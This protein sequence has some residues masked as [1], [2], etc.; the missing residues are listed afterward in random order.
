MRSRKS[1]A[2]LLAVP[3]VCLLAGVFFYFL[4]PVHARLAWRVENLWVGIKRAI[5]PPEQV[6]FVPQEQVDAAVQATLLALTPSPSPVTPTAVGPTDTPPP[7]PTPTSS[8]T[9]IPAQA[10]LTGIVHE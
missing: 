9:P 3:F 6:V 5:N 2:I 4:P 7:S 8:P 10:V 1:V